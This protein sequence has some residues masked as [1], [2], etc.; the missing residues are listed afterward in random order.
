MILDAINEIRSKIAQAGRNIRLVA[1]S[2]GQPVEKILEAIHAGQTDFGENY[3]QEFLEHYGSVRSNDRTS[4]H[5]HFIGHLQRNKVRSIIDKVDLIHSVDS[6][7]LA[8][9]IDKRAA[10]IGKVQS[11]LIEVNLAGEKSKT[12]VSPNNLEGLIACM[13]PME[14]LVLKGLM[15]IPPLLTNPEEVRPYFR[16][17]REIRDAINQKNIYQS[18]LT[19][20]SM[21]MTHDFEVALSEGATIVRIGTGIF[22]ARKKG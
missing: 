8:R 6:I 22:G 12:G 9:E 20:L 7:E 2:K 4:L 18:P 3:A 1:V 21:G 15:T 19:E 17:L 16:Q 10:A 5:W 13:T 14:N 11:I